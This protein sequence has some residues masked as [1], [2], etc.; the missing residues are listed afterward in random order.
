MAQYAHLAMHGIYNVANP[1]NSRLLLT[2]NRQVPEQERVL[3]LR[4]ILQGTV[5]LSGLR[6]L[7][8]S[9][10]ET[11]VIDLQRL[12]DEVIGL[13]AGF[14]QAGVAGVIAS[15]WR[16]GDAATYLLMVRFALH[17]LDPEENS[18][19]ARAL[20]EAQRWLREVAT[21]RVLST[22][23]PL[24]DILIPS[25][26]PEASQMLYNKTLL[27]IRKQAKKQLESAPDACPYAHPKYWAAFIV[28]GS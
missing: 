18:S 13:A 19:P 24:E 14:L 28:T 21:N 3:T 20:A 11:S 15:L 12:P 9:A 26:M 27:K 2:G 23:D 6:L 16:V 25:L 1:L 5:S 4:E 10:C 8:L 7:V 22:Y 17:Y